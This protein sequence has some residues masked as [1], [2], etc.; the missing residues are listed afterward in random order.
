MKTIHVVGLMLWRGGILLV[1]GYVLYLMLRFVLRIVDPVLEIGTALVI[2]GLLMVLASVIGERVADA[3]R[4]KR[5]GLW[6]E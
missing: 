4:E 3:K 2:S 5:E 1:G 6:S